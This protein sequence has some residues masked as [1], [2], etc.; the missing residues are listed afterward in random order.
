MGDTVEIGVPSFHNMVKGRPIRLVF[1]VAMF[2]V[3]LP[4]H[5][6]F[7]SA[8]YKTAALNSLGYTVVAPEYARR[9]F[10]RISNDS[11]IYTNLRDP[12]PNNEWEELPIRE[13]FDK[14]YMQVPTTF[15]HAVV[16]ADHVMGETDPVPD[17]D[18]ILDQVTIE[19]TWL[20]VTWDIPLS[21]GPSN[22]SN[23]Y[24]EGIGL[25]DQY[26]LHA[27]GFSEKFEPECRLLANPMFW[28]LT[29][30]CNLVIAL[31]LTGVAYFHKSNPLITVG[32]AIDSFLTRP[33]ELIPK[34]ASTYDHT[35]FTNM[36]RPQL[37]ARTYNT[38]ARGRGWWQGVSLTRW[39]LTSLWFCLMTFALLVSFFGSLFEMKALQEM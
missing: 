30:V 3:A 2:L 4:I 14:Y 28:S 11:N 29:A 19:S 32:D 20:P 9:T 10:Q 38:E 25:G 13:L 1:W 26:Q 15:R 8:V 31:T 34:S 35:A 39:W 27:T 22:L 5:L 23:V 36:F 21:E 6:V 16:I 33:T 37:V 18:T 17:T 12:R 7:N 24:W